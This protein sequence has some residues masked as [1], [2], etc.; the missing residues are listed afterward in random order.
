MAY[1]ALIAAR[2]TTASETVTLAGDY[3]GVPRASFLLSVTAAATD[4]GDTFDLYLQFSPDGGTTWQDFIHFTQVLGNGGAKKYLAAWQAT[5]APSSLLAAPQ[6]GAL[7]A[8]VRQG[9]I[10]TTIRAKAVV[11]DANADASFTW[12]LYMDAPEIGA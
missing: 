7:A 3:S 8:G 10:G 12:S 6:D 9:P 11:V 5:V 1:R 4:V 2:V